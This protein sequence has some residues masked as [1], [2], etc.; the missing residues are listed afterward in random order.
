MACKGSTGSG[1]TLTLSVDTTI[2]KVRSAQ[3]PDWVIEAVDFTGLSDLNWMCFIPGSPADPGAFSADLFLNTEL[4]IPTL[5]VVQIATFTFPIQT[6]SN[7]VNA[8]LSGSGFLTSVGWGS[9]VVNDPMV[10]PI[11]FKFD[12]NSQPPSFTL[13]SA[14]FA[15]EQKR[16]IDNALAA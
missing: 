4:A 8:T 1:V 12:G 6:P 10:M 3:L 5:K 2:A 14:V 13:E 9:A 16:K 7:A 15:D 11:S